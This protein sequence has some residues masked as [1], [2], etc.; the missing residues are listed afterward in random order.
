VSDIV[1][2]PSALALHRTMLLIRRAEERLSRLFADGEIPGFL[3]LS[4]GQEA[5]AAG[6]CGVL[7][8]ADTIASTHRGHGHALAKGVDLDGFFAEIM[9]RANGLCGGRGGSIHVAEM[10]VGMLGANGIVGGGLPLALGSAWAHQLRAEGTVAVAFFGD[11]ALAE[12]A[13]HECL[14]I[15][16]LWKLPMVFACENNGWS[17]FSPQVLQLAT[18]PQRLAISFGL[19]YEHADGM[20][21]SAVAE[22][23]LACTSHARSGLGAVVL[24]CATQRWHGHFEGDPQKYRAADNLAQAR[25]QDPLA[26]HRSRMLEQGIAAAQIDSLQSEVLAR[27]ERAIERARA[28]SEPDF[29]ATLSDVYTTGARHHG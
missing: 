5:V 20:D 3:H 15:A 10:A 1:Q 18:N 28:G 4:L 14:N 6:I 8:A 22:A 21:V 29:A 11:G 2:I 17:E 9:G 19:R 23:A 12:G 13:I 7:G 24:E 16:A 25:S 26:A 27:I